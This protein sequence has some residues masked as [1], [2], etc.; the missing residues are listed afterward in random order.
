[1]KN[2][3]LV[4][5][6]VSVVGCKG[7]TKAEPCDASSIGS[8]SKSDGKQVAFAGCTF[9]GQGNDMVSFGPTGGGPSVDCTMKGGEGAVKEFRTAAMKIGQDKLKLD[10]RG[11]VAKDALK[12]CEISVHD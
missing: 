8:L 4:S 9:Q 2:I 11:V 3:I 1:M 10:V 5:L 7:S 12:D 6:L